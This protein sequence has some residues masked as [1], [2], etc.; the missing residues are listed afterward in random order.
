[1]AGK[2]RETVIVFGGGLVGSLLALFLGRRGYRVDVYEKRP[3]IRYTTIEEARSINLALSDRGWNALRAL[4]LEDEVKDV[5]LPMYARAMH[6]V[7]GNLTYQ[8]YGKE[9]QA[10]YSVTRFSLNK[11]LVSIAAQMPNVYYHF[12]ARLNSVNLK[13]KEA[14]VTNLLNTE[15]E[16]NA[17]ADFIFGADGAFSNIRNSMQ[18]SDRFDYQQFYIEHGY[19]EFHLSPTEANEWALENDK[20][21]IWPRGT[22]MMIA[23]PNPD[24]SFTCTLFFPFKGPLSFESIT[25]KEQVGEFFQTYFKDLVG[26]MPNHADQYF[27]NPTSSLVTVKCFPW[28]VNNVALIGDA[29]HAIVPF[30][31]Q[32]MN[33]GF[34]DCFTLDQLVE[35]EGSLE[36]ALPKY[37][38]SRKKSADAIADLALANFVEMRD[39]VANPR[40]LL[41]KKIEAGFHRLHPEQ[42]VPMYTQVTFSNIPYEEALASGRLQDHYLSQIMEVTGIDKAELTDVFLEQLWSDFVVEGRKL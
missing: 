8:P 7:E 22:F 12:N 10:I 33:C 32:G 40:F 36:A 38:L 16:Y 4:G 29:A 26:I 27:R 37:Q 41:R 5:G 25:N 6:D 15:D 30:F 23:L 14:N 42:W 13:R 2:K 17:G 19:K 35:Q 21:H 28:V 31:G 18:R 11:R 24:K 39:S 9:G 3:D 20:L 1:M 34:E